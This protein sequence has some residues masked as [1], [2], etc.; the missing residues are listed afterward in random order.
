MCKCAGYSSTSEGKSDCNIELGVWRA[1]SI[2]PPSV[3]PDQGREGGGGADQ[4]G[5][6]VGRYFSSYADTNDGVEGAQRMYPT[7]VVGT[8]EDVP[9]TSPS[10]E[11]AEASR[12]KHVPGSSRTYG[13]AHK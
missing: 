10:L 2:P 3:A 11:A 4:E 7:Q 12:T 6:S 5:G 1:W 8:S 13:S 9:V